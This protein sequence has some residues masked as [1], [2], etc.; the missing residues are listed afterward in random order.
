M[1]N[2][3]GV[4]IHQIKCKIFPNCYDSSSYEK[5]NKLIYAFNTFISSINPEEETYNGNHTQ[6]IHTITCVSLHSK[7]KKEQEL[8]SSTTQV[9]NRVIYKDYL[10]HYCSYSK[11]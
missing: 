4:D 9:H 1:V 7:R 10:K 11:Y 2:N 3:S 8:M 5:D 6:Y